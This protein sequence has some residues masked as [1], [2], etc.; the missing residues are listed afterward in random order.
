MHECQR[1]KEDAN[2]YRKDF[3]DFVCLSLKNEIVVKE[4]EA[5]L[6]FDNFVS[7]WLRIVDDKSLVKSV[8]FFMMR[9]EMEPATFSFGIRI[10]LAGGEFNQEL[11]STIFITAFQTIKQLRKKIMS[12]VFSTRIMDC[13][14]KEIDKSF[15]SKDNSYI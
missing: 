10:M 11:N 13:I 15:F 7:S 8:G 1:T 6:P 3:L 14:E 4:L 2:K 12:D 5:L 9:M